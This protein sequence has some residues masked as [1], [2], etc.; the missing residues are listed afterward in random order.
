MLAPITKDTARERLAAALAAADA[1]VARGTLNVHK[2]KKLIPRAPSPLRK[3]RND[4]LEDLPP[5][6]QKRIRPVA[7]TILTMPPDDIRK[8][9]GEEA[10]AKYKPGPVLRKPTRVHWGVSEE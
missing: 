2:A 8:N 7:N 9:F 4:S 6:S 3:V 1:E 5:S 10:F